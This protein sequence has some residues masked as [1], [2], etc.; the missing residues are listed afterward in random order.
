MNLKIV[1]MGS[2]G[3][4]TAHGTNG[5]VHVPFALPGETINAAVN[6]V[7]RPEAAQSPDAIGPR[8]NNVAGE[9]INSS[10]RG[11]SQRIHFRHVSGQVFVFDWAGDVLPASSLKLRPEAMSL[12]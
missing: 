12:I 3:E 6:I 1:E 9:V 4:G 8:R 2:K 5:P 7:I 11:A 10:F